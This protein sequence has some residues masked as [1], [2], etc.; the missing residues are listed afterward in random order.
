MTF[1]I[2]LIMRRKLKA[3]VPEVRRRN[4]IIEIIIL[5]IEIKIGK[6]IEIE[7]RKDIIINI[8]INL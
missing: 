6:G 1:K 7:I 2:K 3:I 4:I 5:M 8:M